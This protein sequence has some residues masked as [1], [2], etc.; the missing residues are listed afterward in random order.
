MGTV[1]ML[2]NVI[3]LIVITSNAIMLSVMA[4]TKDLKAKKKKLV[5]IFKILHNLIL[6]VFS[7]FFIDFW[8]KKKKWIFD[9]S[10]YF[11][12]I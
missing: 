6:K 9:F 4:P 1:I 7:I 3:M 10:R 11:N 12:P 2:K 8:F 5:F